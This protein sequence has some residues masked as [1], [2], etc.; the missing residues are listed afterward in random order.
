MTSFMMDTH[1][2]RPWDLCRCTGLGSHRSVRPF[3][4]WL[5]EKIS[6][7]LKIVNDV[8]RRKSGP[9]HT[10]CSKGTIPGYFE[11][12]FASELEIVDYAADSSKD[13]GSGF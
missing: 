1:K 7:Q 12:I 2:E 10:N 11:F 8:R 4:R 3:K 6:I 9:S 13:S 5:G